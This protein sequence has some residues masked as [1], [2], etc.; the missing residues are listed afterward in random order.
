MR[1]AEELPQN[2]VLRVRRDTSARSTTVSSL[3]HSAPWTSW[4]VAA[5]AGTVLLHAIDIVFH[6]MSPSVSELLQKFALCS[7]FY[8]APH[9]A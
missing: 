3:K 8:G 1:G 4:L 5:I 9:C 2:G 7:T 6:P